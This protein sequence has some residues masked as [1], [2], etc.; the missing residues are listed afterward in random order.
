M[1]KPLEP[2]GRRPYVRL[3]GP[4]RPC[5]SPVPTGAPGHDVPQIQSALRRQLKGRSSR[6]GIQLCPAVIPPPG[7]ITMPRIITKRLLC[8]TGRQ[9]VIL[10]RK[11]RLRQP[12]TRIWQAG[13]VF[14]PN[15]TPTR[16]AKL[17]RVIMINRV[18]GKEAVTTKT[19]YQPTNLH[20]FMCLILSHCRFVPNSG[21][22]SVQQQRKTT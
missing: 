4:G 1:S 16:H 6:G 8:T 5:P 10:Q 9:N 17:M 7:T 2:A 15:S 21:R 20:G 22:Q 11:S 12:G 14:R 3:G 13:T 18:H 19:A